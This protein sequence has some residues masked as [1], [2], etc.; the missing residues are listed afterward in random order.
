MVNIIVNGRARMVDRAILTY[1]DIVRLAHNKPRTDAIY[2]VCYSG[3]RKGD[4]R[5]SGELC[6]GELV[7]IESGMVFSAMVTDGA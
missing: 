6:P 3:P 4:S 1:D 2:T 7:E 5:R